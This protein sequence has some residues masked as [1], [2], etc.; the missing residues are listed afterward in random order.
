ME[1]ITIKEF[2]EKYMEK[3]YTYSIR[4]YNTETEYR[5][6]E[7]DWDDI[8]KEIFDTNLGNYLVVKMNSNGLITTAKADVYSKVK[9]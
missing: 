7:I 4:F 6:I 5:D 8:T 9:K 1:T 2:F 3:D